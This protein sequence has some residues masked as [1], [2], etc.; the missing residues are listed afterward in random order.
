MKQFSFWLLLISILTWLGCGGGGGSKKTTISVTLSPTSASVATGHFTQFAATVTGS[1]TSSAVVWSVNSVAGGNTTVGTIT[2]AGLYTAPGTI[3]TGGSV[4]VSATSAEDTSKSA[5]ATV[6]I[7]QAADLRVAPSFATV[8]AGGQ[9]TFVPTINGNAAVVTWQVNCPNLPAGACGS[10]TAGGVY[11][12]PLYP[13]PS[14]ILLNATETANPSDSTSAL[15]QVQIS[16][17][18]LLGSYAFSFTGENGG[19]AYRAA[20]SIA[21]DGAGHITGGIADESG[22]G[23]SSTI[24]ITGGTYTL[25]TDGRGSASVTTSSG[26]QNW[27][28]AINSHSHGEAARFDATVVANGSLDLQDSTQF[29]L[30]S[31]TGQYS[32]GLSGNSSSGSESLAGVLNA[33]GSG[34]LSQGLIDA[35]NAGTV[36]VNQTATGSYTVASTDGRGTMTITSGAGNHSFAYYVVDGTHLKLVETGSSGNLSGDAIQQT[37]GPYADA[38]LTRSYN[39]VWT[40]TSGNGPI[41]IGGVLSLDGTGHISSGKVDINDAGTISFGS[42][43]T[44]TYSVT[45]ATTG[46]TTL[47][48]NVASTP[49]RTLQFVLYPQSTTA[50]NAVQ[51]DASS[52]SG[53]VALANSGSFTGP[54][55]LNGSFATGVGGTDLQGTAGAE[56]IAGVLA[57]NGGGALSGTLDINDKGALSPGATVTGG[58][59]T[60]NGIG[61]ATFNGRHFNLYVLDVNNALLL[62]TD[63]NQVLGGAIHKQ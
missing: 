31:I 7:T 24:N 37:N 43:A 29:S 22:T 44:G 32:L 8:P 54:G 19:N 34:N 52:V 25:G 41:A 61:S 45:D 5:S 18:S 21:F 17:K 63:T 1:T 14:N 6:T 51:L 55:T 11:T 56:A 62:G 57:P 28:F 2:N 3:P 20:G 39:F 42:A 23:S 26:T 46:R 40:G 30:A 16:P 4:T 53:G 59:Y 15:I 13:P 36:K 60:V 35:N 10:I 33:N 27:R 47:S 38:A 50:F 58:T 49:P 12:A 48:I 9:Q